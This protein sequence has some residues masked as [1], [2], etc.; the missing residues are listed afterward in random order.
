MIFLKYNIKEKDS[1][2]FK[3]ACQQKFMKSLVSFNF[4]H[5]VEKQKN[6]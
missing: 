1:Q 6:T 5:I 2:L 3:P 4:R